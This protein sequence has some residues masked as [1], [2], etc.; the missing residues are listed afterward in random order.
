MKPGTEPLAQFLFPSPKSGSRWSHQISQ[1]NRQITAPSSHK[2]PNGSTP[3][4]K[5]RQHHTSSCH[6]HFLQYLHYQ[7]Q[8]CIVIIAAKTKT[9][10]TQRN[11]RRSQRICHWTTHRQDCIKRRSTQP[12]QASCRFRSTAT[13]IADA[14]GCCL[15]S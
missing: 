9:T 12:L 3:R 8:S 10:H 7:Q 1:P 4:S 13:C 11:I 5:N 6:E 2:P 14:T 15:S